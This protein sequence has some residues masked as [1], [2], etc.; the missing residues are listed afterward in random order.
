M[1]TNSEIISEYIASLKFEDIPR[2]VVDQTKKVLLHTIAAS[3]AAYPLP[4]T[5]KVIRYTQSKGG[6]QESTIWCS[7][8]K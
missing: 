6:L 5:D 2:D 3:I 1:K 8:G 7:D 4:I